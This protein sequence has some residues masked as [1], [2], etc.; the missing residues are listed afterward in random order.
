MVFESVHLEG[1]K[2]ETNFQKIF[3]ANNESSGHLVD[4]LLS[5]FFDLFTSYIFISKC[6]TYLYAVVYFFQGL[7]VLEIMRNIHVFV[8]KY[9]YNLNNQV[10]LL[11]YALYV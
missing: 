11:R 1:I 8:A 10:M 9:A 2:Q 4:K 7:D 5:K 6:P 3:K